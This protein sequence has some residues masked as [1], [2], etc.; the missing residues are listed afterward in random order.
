M[1]LEACIVYWGI[2]VHAI[3]SLRGSKSVKHL[4][5]GCASSVLAI[6]WTA[7]VMFASSCLCESNL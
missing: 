2:V 1:L 5:V 6:A 3:C 4:V 7:S